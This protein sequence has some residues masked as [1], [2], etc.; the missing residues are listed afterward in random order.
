[1]IGNKKVRLILSVKY[2]SIHTV[3]KFTPDYF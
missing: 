3:K 1:M 2:S